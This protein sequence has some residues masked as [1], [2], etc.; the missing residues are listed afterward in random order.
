MYWEYVPYFT[1]LYNV[2]NNKTILLFF[3]YAQLKCLFFFFYFFQLMQKRRQ[4]TQ[5]SELSNKQRK[6]QPLHIK[7][8]INFL[9][10]H[11]RKLNYI[12]FLCTQQMLKVK[13]WLLSF[14]CK[15]S[16]GEMLTPRCSVMHRS[17][18]LVNGKCCV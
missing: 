16:L 17:M 10:K 9:M 7:M 13:P 4:S 2:K 3:N 5:M 1:I 6:Q 18:N 15:I 8:Q 14:P 12:Y 11:V